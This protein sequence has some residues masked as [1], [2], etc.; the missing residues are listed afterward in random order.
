MFW[1]Q[2]KTPAY[3]TSSPIQSIDN[4]VENNS[5]YSVTEFSTACS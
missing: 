1:V 4:G 5:T 2:M 3:F